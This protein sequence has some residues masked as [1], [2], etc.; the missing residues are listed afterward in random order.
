MNA[1]VLDTIHKPT[2]SNAHV[3]IHNYINYTHIQTYSKLIT[4]S[5]QHIW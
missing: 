5:L 3:V 4:G 2:D 1:P